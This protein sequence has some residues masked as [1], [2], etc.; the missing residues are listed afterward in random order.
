MDHSLSLPGAVVI[1]PVLPVSDQDRLGL[2]VAGDEA[3]FWELWNEC[4][5][6]LLA[7]C[8]SEMRGRHAD[9][10]DALTLTMLKARE[11]L[12]I[13]GGEIRAVRG[14]L[15]Q[16]AR[17]TCGDVKRSRM[18]QELM[19][20]RWEAENGGDGEAGEPADEGLM[21]SEAEADL[22]R[23]I[24]TLPEAWRQ[25]F[26]LRYMRGLPCSEVAVQLKLSP[27]NVRKRL[28]HSRNFLR[29]RQE[30]FPL[31][32]YGTKGRTDIRQ[33]AGRPSPRLAETQASRGPRQTVQPPAGAPQLAPV[34]LPC[35]VNHVFQLFA[36]ERSR[37]DRR[38]IR[39]L[40]AYVASHPR[41]W[42]KLRELGELLYRG[43]EWEQALGVW[44]AMPSRHRQE[45]SLVLKMGLVLQAFGRGEEAVAV[46]AEGE[47]TIREGASRQH[48]RG[49]AAICRK[50][51]GAAIREFTAATA[52]EKQNPLHWHG[53]AVAR[54]CGGLAPQAMAALERALEFNP[55]DLTA[56]MMG[57]GV[58]L[59]QNRTE[60]AARWAG[61]I[62]IL[63]PNDPL[64]IK[65]VAGDRCRQRMVRGAAGAK[66]KRLIQQTT[67]GFPKPGGGGELLAEFLILRGEA[68]RGLEAPL[69]FAKQHPNCVAGWERYARLAELAGREREA[70]AGWER[71]RRL[72]E[73]NPN[74]CALTCRLPEFRLTGCDVQY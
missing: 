37:G 18:R 27:G 69:R 49:W 43:G 41:G 70:T 7:L 10:E 29:Q 74:H 68:N 64:T 1:N 72:R 56:L 32:H 19:I 21:R 46:Y 13:H 8:L 62:L 58:L 40:S 55:A 23:R 14:W 57:H 3:A 39:A 20:E 50:D 51:Y 33:P 4:R 9:A 11:L 36:G 38:R 59:E 48:L 73:E 44:Y 53:L 22:N 47:R 52:L 25:P 35:G 17:F 26:V 15:G 67:Q 30:S 12:P 71:A 31:P 45:F 66:T 34:R 61:R 42:R 6:G 16:L 65:R 63:A 28:Q 60:E 2:L 54:Y 5:E 24:A